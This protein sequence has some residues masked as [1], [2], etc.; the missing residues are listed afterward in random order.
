[1]R[2]KSDACSL[3]RLWA[4]GWPHRMEASAGAAQG[5]GRVRPRGT[6]SPEKLVSQAYA[7]ATRVCSRARRSTGLVSVPASLSAAAAE[8]TDASRTLTRPASRADAQPWPRLPIGCAWSAKRVTALGGLA[9]RLASS[10][11]NIVKVLSASRLGAPQRR[12][13]SPTDAPARRRRSGATTTERTARNVG[14]LSAPQGS[15]EYRT[16]PRAR[17]RSRR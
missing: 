14:G 16:R 11:H 7:G 3:S 10:A 17:H 8:I 1:M 9:K 5:R 6:R 15:L 4:A 13:R 2:A 12:R